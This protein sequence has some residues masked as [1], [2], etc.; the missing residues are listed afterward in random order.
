MIDFFS[1]MNENM[2]TDFNAN[3]LMPFSCL[4]VG[5]SG[6][7]KTFFVNKVLEHCEHILNCMPENTGL[8]IHLFP[9]HV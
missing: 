7:G 5:P 1:C 9:T 4:L 8:D 2:E 3:L 6:C